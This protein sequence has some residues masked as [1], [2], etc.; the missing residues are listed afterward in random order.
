[1]ID[2]VS[3]FFDDGGVM[4]DNTRRGKQWK[5]LIADF[6]A[7]RYG[8]DRDAW[9][10]GNQRFIEI[11]SEKLDDLFRNGIDLDHA[12]YQAFE[13]KISI[14]HMFDHVGITR[15]PERDYY[16]INREKEAW[17]I[18]RVKADIQGMIPTIKELKMSGYDLYTASGE[19]S[20]VLKG[21]LRGMGIQELF[22]NFYGPDIVGMM[23]GGLEFY[24]RIFDHARVNLSSVIVIDDRPE[25]LKLVEQ[26]GARAIQSCVLNEPTGNHLHYRDP[27]ELPALIESLDDN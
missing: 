9:R 12:S 7:P 18:P 16:K 3:I 24:R 19:T 15:P 13:D 26:L 6:F 23:K 14:V 1:M 22:S 5:D 8:G 2:R 27:K 4:N 25:M 11:I 17:I 20:W 21:Y 10:E